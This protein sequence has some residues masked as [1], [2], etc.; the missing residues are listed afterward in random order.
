MKF[1]EEAG[2]SRRGW[3]RLLAAALMLPQVWKYIYSPLSDVRVLHTDIDLVTSSVAAPFD[4][5]RMEVDGK[6]IGC[7]LTPVIGDIKSGTSR[8]ITYHITT[9][10]QAVTI[11]VVR[12][13]HFEKSIYRLVQASIMNMS[14][15][16]TVD[17]KL[18][19]VEDEHIYSVKAAASERG[20]SISIC[21]TTRPQWPCL[22]VADGF[23]VSSL[24]NPEPVFFYRP[25]I[26]SIVNIV[27]LQ[28]STTHVKTTD[29]PK[30]ITILASFRNLLSPGFTGAL[31][32]TFRL[33]SIPEN[34]RLTRVV[35][36]RGAR[37][38]VVTPVIWTEQ[39]DEG[40]V[41]NFIDSGAVFPVSD[42]V[43]EMEFS[44][45][46]KE[47]GPEF[48]QTSYRVQIFPG[49]WPQPGFPLAA[50]SANSPESSNLTYSLYTPGN[51]KAFAVDSH[52]GWKPIPRARCW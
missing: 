24:T 31:W 18:V 42:I 22:P 37:M 38:R 43:Y 26:G 52:T 46:T 47:A 25:D 34:Y 8:R 23:I 35:D 50:I 3:G 41:L 7:T 39:Q 13:V 4:I 20:T 12:I 17:G 29:D 16:V 2:E 21:V 49:A 5:I 44:E 32:G 9:P 30:K 33:P 36:Q 48:D 1:S 28:Y 15:V 19:P 45:P 14:T 11:H 10:G 27:P 40:K 51:E 6:Q